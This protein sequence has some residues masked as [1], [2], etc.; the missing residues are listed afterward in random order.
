MITIRIATILAIALSG[1][2]VNSS[3]VVSQAYAAGGL[4]SLVAHASDQC[5]AGKVKDWAGICFNKSEAKACPTCAPGSAAAAENPNT[6]PPEQKI[7]KTQLAGGGGLMSLVAH[8]SQDVYL[9]H[10]NKLQ[11]EVNKLQSEENMLQSEVNKLQADDN[12]LQ[13]E[14]NKTK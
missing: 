10:E 13:S 11:S 14:A 2:L 1:V 6:S 4:M 7:T 5:P 12:K 8:G 9:T 3:A